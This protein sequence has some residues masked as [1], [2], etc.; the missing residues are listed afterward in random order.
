M[1][2]CVGV[3]LRVVNHKDAFV[4]ARAAF[5]PAVLVGGLA[6]ASRFSLGEVESPKWR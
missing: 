2:V 3:P 6:L 5:V 1:Y 4:H